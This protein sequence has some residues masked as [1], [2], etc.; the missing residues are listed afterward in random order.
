MRSV[1]AQQ[2]A[3]IHESLKQSRAGGNEP[4]WKRARKSVTKGEKKSHVAL[5]A[6]Q[7]HRK[8]L[9]Q[10]E[11]ER[12]ARHE[13][14]IEALLHE[15]VV[16]KSAAVLELKRTQRKRHVVQPAPRKRF[17]GPS[18]DGNDYEQPEESAESAELDAYG[19]IVEPEPVVSIAKLQ[20]LKDNDSDDEPFA[21]Y[22]F[23]D[24]EDDE[25]EDD[26]RPNRGAK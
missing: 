7:R 2:T 8:L 4:A 15:P 9:E 24:A 12:A 22:R 14:N 10:T 1:L 19:D 26:A 25:E 17:D 3:A 16:S 18:L 5:G 11:E 20:K 13:H 6:L 21:I 23:P